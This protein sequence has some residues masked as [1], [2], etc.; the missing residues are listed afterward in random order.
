[1]CEGCVVF[2]NTDIINTAFGRN[3]FGNKILQVMWAGVRYAVTDKLDVIAA[4]YHYTQN[5]YYGTP[6]AGPLPCSGSE[7]S[8]CAGTFGSE[9]GAGFLHHRQGSL[10]QAPVAERPV[11]LPPENQGAK[12]CH[13][14]SNHRRRRALSAAPRLFLTPAFEENQRVFAVRCPACGRAGTY[15]LDY[16]A[17]A[18]GE[19]DHGAASVAR[20]NLGNFLP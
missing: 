12:S 3:G 15:T 11:A 18:S 8:Q 17:L 14:Y 20:F 16:S 2:N 4:Y 6:T 19:P 1:M 10:R 5:S 7:H 13:C 9:S